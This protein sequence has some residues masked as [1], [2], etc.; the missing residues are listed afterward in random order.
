MARC[1]MF[2]AVVIAGMAW[3]FPS[4]ATVSVF[5]CEP[6]WAALAREIG[7]DR[8]DA[9]AATHARQDPHHIRARPSL[10]AR[11]RRADLLF[12]SGGGLEA[13]WLPIL[14]QRGAPARLQPGQPGH[15][16]AA[17]HVSVLDKPAVLDRSLGD[18]HPEGNPHV[19]LDARNMIPLAR[20][21][22]RR[23]AAIDP[24][25]AA[26]YEANA[27]AFVKT[28][29]ASLA[30]W[31]KRAERLQGMPVIVHHKTWSYLLH[32]LGLEELAALEPKPGVPPTTSHLNTL[33]RLSRSKSVTAVLLTPF[34]PPDAALWLSKR[35]G[36]PVVVLPYT[37]DGDAA[38]GALD[39]L[40]ER[41][42]KL[43]E[44]VRER[45]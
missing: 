21:L 39:A 25:N 38:S 23:L 2:V 11:I 29:S 10:I 17:D 3:P 20:E 34:D 35:T 18:I 16:L 30:K 36:V 40:F 15:L 28:W 6:E 41:T 43:L 24:P 33:L 32:W 31:S 5:A 22:G 12:C 1:H 27:D 42:I 44:D 7:A 19:H 8:V 45:R 26:S 4:S 37:V 9:F 13:G 14:L